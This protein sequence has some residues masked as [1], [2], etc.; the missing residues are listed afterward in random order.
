MAKGL[1][2]RATSRRSRAAYTSRAEWPTA[3]TT[4]EAAMVEPSAWEGE[5]ARQ[6]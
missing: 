2:V 3:S 6:G 4:R 1:G 5:G